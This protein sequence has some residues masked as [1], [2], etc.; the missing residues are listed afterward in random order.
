MGAFD[1]PETREVLSAKIS[2]YA[3]AGWRE[4]CATHG[5]TITAMLEVA[6]R[7]LAKETDPPIEPRR[8]MIAKARQVD[9]QR[10]KRK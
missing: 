6:G 10:R 5:V 8:A 4:F 7:E 3:V 1:D 2:S 9:L